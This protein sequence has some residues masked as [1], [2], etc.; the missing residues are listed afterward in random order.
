MDLIAHRNAHGNVLWPPAGDNLGALKTAGI[1]S[2]M[3][4]ADETALRRHEAIGFPVLSAFLLAAALPNELLPLGSPIFGVVALAPLLLAIYRSQS[5]GH[6]AAMGAL[7]GGVSTLLTSFWL[8]FFQSFSVWTLGGVT[9]AY[10]G[11]NALLAPFL[12]ATSRVPVAYRP[13]AVACTWALY[14]YLKSVGFLGYPWG[15]IAY[16]VHNIL[17]LIQI[18]EITGVWGLSLLMAIVNAIVAEWLAVSGANAE[19]RGWRR[20]TRELWRYPLVR[21]T[22]LGT[23]LVAATLVFGWIALA[24]PLERTA[25][26][27]L[28]LIQHNSNPWESGDLA[29]AVIILQRLTDNAIAAA[30]GTPDIVVWSETALSRPIVGNERY[31][32]R[33]PEERP[34]LPYLQR[35][36]SHLLT[37]V[38][39][40]LKWEPLQTMNAAMLAGPGLTAP[41]HYGKQHPVP[42]AESVP[43]W[44]LP[45]VR[46][47]FTNVIGLHAVW[48]SG[49]EV[50]IFEV[51]LHAGGTL[52][53]ATPICF[54]DAFSALGR[55]FVNAGADAFINITN[56][57]WSHTVTAETQHLVA[58][59]L[60]AVENRRVLVRGTNGGVTTVID[61]HGRTLAQ[62]PLLQ[63]A[64]LRVQVPIYR[65]LRT[66]YTQLGDVLPIPLA[67][68]VLTSLIVTARQGR[69]KVRSA[70]PRAAV[71]TAL[72]TPVA[73]LTR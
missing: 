69:M 24:R 9:L 72:Q 38:P 53:F 71:S 6:A 18:V 10:V 35:L 56:D 15:L 58:A 37:G 4:L 45:F 40:V 28:A 44:E 61:P 31:F 51:P 54:E 68:V 59:K 50:T 14:E 63:E 23:V 27:D 48:Q 25:T 11:F 29:G 42:F 67:M 17:P 21:S 60:R 20:S 13:F 12:R 34:L 57:A 49:T 39:W 5:T 8:L 66:L 26:A 43:F 47:F 30:P 7:F 22:A 19:R 64:F 65:G 33:V 52:R 1:L 3:L 2:K 55:Q 16:P 73:D 36:K 32:S 46:R 62:A 70:R 41:R